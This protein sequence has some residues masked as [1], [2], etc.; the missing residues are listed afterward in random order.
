VQGELPKELEVVLEE[1]TYPVK[2]LGTRVT[3]QEGVATPQS[4][5]QWNNRSVD[6][7]TWE[8]NAVMRGQFP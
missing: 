7:V 1:T 6:D 4:L 2:V 5:I 3:M 8:D